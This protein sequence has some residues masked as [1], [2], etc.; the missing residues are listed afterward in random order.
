MNAK[1][2]TI[3][4]S[5]IGGL[6]FIAVTVYMLFSQRVKMN[7]GYVTG[8]TA[9]NLYNGGL[10][11]ESEGVIYFSN[12]YDDGCL[13]SMLPDETDIKKLSTSASLPSTRIPIICT[14]IWT[15]PK[16]GEL[17]AA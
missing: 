6:A 5:A 2:K 15:A 3:V 13:Y 9:G 7:E 17:R 8:N 12:L 16:R 10:F 4:F 11:C 14:I 1:T